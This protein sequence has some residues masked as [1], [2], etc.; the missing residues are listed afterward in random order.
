M[1]DDKGLLVV[2]FKEVFD[3]TWSLILKAGVDF[4]F[5]NDFWADFTTVVSWLILAPTLPLFP[6]VLILVGFAVVKDE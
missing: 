4:W 5:I 1:V 3:V 2:S 6:R